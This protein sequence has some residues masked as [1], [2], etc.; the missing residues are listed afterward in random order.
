VIDLTGITIAVT[1]AGRGLGRSMACALAHAGGNVMLI[2]RH[3]ADVTALA[4][5]LN[6][7]LHRHAGLAIEADITQSA[8]CRRIL[9]D[10]VASFGQIDVL[11]NNARRLHRGPDLPRD[12][13]SL[14]LWETDPA[15]WQETVHVNINGSFLMTYHL[16]THMRARGWGR[17]INITTSLGTMQRKHNSPYGV[18]KAALEAATL[19]WAQDLEGSGVTCNSLLPGG[20][21]N[22]GYDDAYVKA[23]P[24]ALLDVGVMDEAV[25][26]LASPLSDDMNGCRVNGSLWRRDLDPRAAAHHACEAPVLRLP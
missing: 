21:V 4:H 7:T 14:P 26:F 3:G 18:T 6:E 13:N 11:V 1:G 10:G 15:I 8:D 12:G 2:D 5:E 19:I 16:V 24:K 23:Q 9:A 22:T 20:S 25:V 17:I